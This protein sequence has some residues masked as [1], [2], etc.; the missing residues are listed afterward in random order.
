MKLAEAQEGDSVEVDPDSDLEK[1]LAKSPKVVYTLTRLLTSQ[2]SPNQVAKN[3]IREI[4]ADVK[5]ISY[6]PTTFRMIF[7]NSNYFDLIYDP[8][9][10][11]LKTPENFTP[12]DSF[13]IAIL[14]KRYDLADDSS[15][16]QAL[17]YIGQCMKYNPI[18][19]SNPDLQQQADQGAESGVDS[20][21]PDKTDKPE[22]DE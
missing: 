11:E 19:S 15:F 5:V 22:K 16:Q 4:L 13:R 2:K 18:D 3:E 14:G 21:L 6:R 12:M 9:P 20:E 8:T 17:D 1:L 7:K 10:Q